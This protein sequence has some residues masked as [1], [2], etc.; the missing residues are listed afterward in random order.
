MELRLRGFT[1]R[2]WRPGD[3]TS[4]VRHANDRTI[5][6]CLRDRFP[7]PYG[8]RHARAWIATRASA[9]PVSQLAIVVDGAA[10]GGIGL[11]IGDDVHRRSAEI[12]YWLGRAF[13]G[14]GIMT[15]AVR[16]ATAYAFATFDLCRI[17]A[18][19]FE[20]NRASMRVLEKAGYTPEGRLRKHVTKAGRTLDEFVYAVVR[21]GTCAR[22]RA[23]ARSRG[24]DDRESGTRRPRT[25]ASRRRG[26]A[27]SSR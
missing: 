16:A 15:R 23:P 18:G 21:R 19:V 4:L 5:W 1:L 26:R 24:R 11:T 27:A 6:L 13:W 3:E 7:H 10:V 20:G 14:R 17:W 2:P 12:G 22:R 8:L 25:A 9:K